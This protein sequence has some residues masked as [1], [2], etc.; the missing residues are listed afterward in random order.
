MF[1]RIFNFTQ[2]MIEFYIPSISLMLLLL[3]FI[4]GIISRYIFKDPQT[5][6]Y[7]LN[8]IAFYVTSLFSTCLVSRNNQN[9]VFDM[10]YNKFSDR[11]KCI[12]RIVSNLLIC[13][14]AIV[15]LPYSIKFLFSLKGLSTQVIKMPRW[16][17]FIGFC[18]ML[19]TTIL[20]FFIRLILDIN[21][22]RSKSYIENYYEVD[23]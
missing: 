20:Y 7:E 8:S 12:M 22:F 17:P 4:I 11:T 16:L 9:V 10:I 14:F 15:L 21:S 6:T 3:S 2:K 18:I 23:Y 1:K 13:L 5:W 19:I